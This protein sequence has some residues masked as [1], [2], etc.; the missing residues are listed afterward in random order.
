MLLCNVCRVT[1]KSPDLPQNQIISIWTDNRAPPDNWGGVLDFTNA[2][3]YSHFKNFRRVIC[4]SPLPENDPTVMGPAWLYG[5][6]E[7]A[8]PKPVKSP[9]L[10]PAVD[11]SVKSFDDTDST[12]ASGQIEMG[13]NVGS[14]SSKGAVSSSDSPDAPSASPPPAASNRAA[15]IGATPAGNAAVSSDTDN[16]NVVNAAGDTEGNATVTGGTAS[17]DNGSVSFASG[18]NASGATNSSGGR[19]TSGASVYGRGGWY[20]VVVVAASAFVAAML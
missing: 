12:L 10:S 19:A 1:F 4:D 9:S 2:P 8:A 13:S 7:T 17:L 14:D 11:E 15:G 3:F 5:K 16:T 6:A 20:A 18:S